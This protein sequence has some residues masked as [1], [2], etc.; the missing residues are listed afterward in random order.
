LEREHLISG[1][2]IDSNESKRTI[3]I[4]RGLETEEILPLAITFFHELGFKVDLAETAGLQSL[5]QGAKLCQSASCAP[6]QLFAGG[7]K[8]LEDRDFV[9]L[10][11]VIEIAGQMKKVL[12]LPLSQAMPDL[13]PKNFNPSSAALLNFKEGYEKT[14]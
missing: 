14:R 4:P 2:P 12:C 1:L 8:F 9:F 10:P 6:F 7:I 5:E 3:G 11:Q 13:F